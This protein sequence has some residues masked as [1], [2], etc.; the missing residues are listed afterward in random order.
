MINI[1]AKLCMGLCANIVILIISHGGFF[2]FP[3]LDLSRF[4]RKP[5]QIVC[6]FCSYRKPHTQKIMHIILPTWTHIVWKFTRSRGVKRSLQIDN[7]RIH[8]EKEFAWYGLQRNSKGS[9]P[10]LCDLLV[11]HGRVSFLR[12]PSG[13]N[14]LRGYKTTH[15][16]LLL[17]CPHASMLLFFIMTLYLSISPAAVLTLTGYSLLPFL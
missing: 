9:T 12:Q 8:R 10:F 4:L 6:Q 13:S 5:A 16:C 2:K 14:S 15:T 1:S 17:I 11:F 3:T 7:W